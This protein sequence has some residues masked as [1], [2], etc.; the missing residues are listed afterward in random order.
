MKHGQELAPLLRAYRVG[1]GLT[2]QEVGRLIGT[3]ASAVAHYE[4]G[5]RFPR[6]RVARRLYALMTGDQSPRERGRS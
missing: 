3:G 4:T 6:P 2:Q 1:R 5:R